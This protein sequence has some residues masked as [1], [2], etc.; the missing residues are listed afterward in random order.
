M[1]KRIIQRLTVGARVAIAKHSITGNIAQLRHDLRNGPSHVFGDHTQCSSDFCT[2]QPLTVTTVM[3][4][5]LDADLM[6]DG[7]TQSTSEPSSLREQIEMIAED[8]ESEQLQ[9]TQLDEQDAAQAGLP[10]SMNTLPDSLFNAVSQC[11]DHIVSLAP[12][13]IA[14]QTSNL[15]ECYMSIRCLFDGGKCFNRIQR[16]S[17]QHRCSAA[18]LATQHGPTWPVSF[19]Q[20]A[21]H[22]TPGTVLLSHTSSKAEQKRRDH[23]R[24]GTQQ[25]KA[26]RQSV[27]INSAAPTD[28]SYGPNAQQDDLPSTELL[29]LCQEFYQREVVISADRGLYIG[30]N[31]RQQ[32]DDSLWHQ[33]RKLRLT[34]SNF[35]K[36]S[37][38]RSTTPVANL[39]KSLLYGKL[40]STEATR[41][42]SAHEVD[43]KKQ[44]LE[45]LRT[46]GHAGA[47]VE[48]SGLVISLEDPCL[49]CSPDGLVE[50]PGSVPDRG[51]LEIKCPHKIAKEGLNPEDA[52]KE[53]KSF[54]CRIG[55][56]KK[57]ELKRSHDYFYQVQGA[58]AITKRSWCDF[59][60]W[61]P[62]G[63]TVERIVF[64][65]SFWEQSKAKIAAFY[66]T[67]ILPELAAPRHPRRQAIREP[68][69]VHDVT[70]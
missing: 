40:F 32:A 4:S 39:V 24:K 20:K 52:A 63:M 67:A 55:D 1:T 31:T 33:Q 70:K 38:R 43:A 27:R 7:T 2:Y 69:S 65:D 19:W 50:I 56:S 16:G 62:N 46:E 6:E 42:G 12:Q 22:S 29:Q 68:T 8:L 10:S 18:A 64:D 21:T 26:Q 9:A 54:F 23:S 45:Y 53:S 34:S 49:A 15:A 66:S 57:P 14:N 3:V 17:F 48:D 25:Y 13:L 61:T 47:C 5:E 28:N 59:I 44:Y 11:C 60:V 35:G 37:K 41:W 30:Q 51:I 36:V 58:M